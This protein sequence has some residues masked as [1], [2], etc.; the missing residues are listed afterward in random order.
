MLVALWCWSGRRGFCYVGF[1]G[2]LFGNMDFIL[3]V[4]EKILISFNVR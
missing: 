2:I 3:K 4:G 1:M